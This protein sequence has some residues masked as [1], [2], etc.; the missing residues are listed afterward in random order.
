VSE[1][2]FATSNKGFAV[3]PAVPFEKMSKEEREEWKEMTERERDRE[4][5]RLDKPVEE[6]FV[7]QEMRQLAFDNYETTDDHGMH[8]IGTAKSQDG[9][10]FYKVKNSWGDY[11]EHNGYFYVSKPYVNYKTMSIMV[12]KDAV[13]KNIREKL[14]L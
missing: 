11:N 6:V 10:V 13:P 4:L 14:K 2:G 8:I 5:Y 9:K 3:L 7:T 12:H 1:K